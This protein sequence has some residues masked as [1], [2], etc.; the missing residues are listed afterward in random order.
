MHDWFAGGVGEIN[1][2]DLGEILG[3]DVGDTESVNLISATGSIADAE[4][5]LYE[6]DEAVC[7]SITHLILEMARNKEK[8]RNEFWCE[9]GEYGKWYAYISNS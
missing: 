8:I 1:S 9:G 3:D 4:D 7:V 6:G 2:V 5:T